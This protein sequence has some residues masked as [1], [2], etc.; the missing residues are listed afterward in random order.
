MILSSMTDS[1]RVEELR[2]VNELLRRVCRSGTIAGGYPRDVNLGRDASDIDLWIPIRYYP[3]AARRIELVMELGEALG[4]HQF[5]KVG[6]RSRITIHEALDRAREGNPL[7]ALGPQGTYTTGGPTG[8]VEAWEAHR[9]FFDNRGGF[10]P[11]QVIFTSQPSSENLYRAFHVGL[12]QYTVDRDGGILA[13]PMAVQDVANRT[14][15]L[16]N[17]LSN[18]PQKFAQYL[19][20]I[21]LKY[22]DHRVVM[23]IPVTDPQWATYYQTLLNAGVLNGPR[24]MV[25]AQSEVTS[26]NTIRLNNR[27]GIGWTSWNG[28]ITDPIPPQPTPVHDD[29]ELHARLL[30]DAAQQRALEAL[31]QWRRIRAETP[32][33]R[34]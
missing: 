22:P 24:Q 20:K 14:L 11:L 18:T 27:A 31:R 3:D 34:G 29:A 9:E 28:A 26:G 2:H 7:A 33:R 10:N 25:Q 5:S 16:H 23:N 6:V 4:Q 30:G 17:P 8:Y 15:T 32:V 19:S 21:K 12:T 1:E 13:S